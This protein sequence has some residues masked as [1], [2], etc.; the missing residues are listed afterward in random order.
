MWKAVV[1]IDNNGGIGKD[2]D[3]LFNNKRDLKW[4]KDLTLFNTVLMGRNTWD[5]L[6]N[7]YL[8]KRANIVLTRDPSRIYNFVEVTAFSSLE[9]AKTF[10]DTQLPL[11]DTFV[12]GGGKVYKQTLEF[13]DVLYITEYETTTL[14][15]TFFPKLDGSWVLV[16]ESKKYEFEAIP[17][18][19]K[20]YF[21]DTITEEAA[22]M[23]I[24]KFSPLLDWEYI[25]SIHN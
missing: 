24:E 21:R 17:Y 11:S 23:S 12:I 16:A 13:C 19:H 14:A 3:L 22:S 10:I 5:S 20:V 25:N 8:P 18:S 4:F 2:N 6:P 7:R 9:A 1:A 15:D